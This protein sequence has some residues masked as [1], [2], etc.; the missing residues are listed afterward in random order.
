MYERIDP[1]D[2]ITVLDPGYQV[3]VGSNVNT[4]QTLA[5]N[6]L[7]AVLSVRISP[8]GA[9]VTLTIVKVGILNGM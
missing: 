8:L 6:E 9:L 5:N 1:S 2:G 7:R 3:D 4:P